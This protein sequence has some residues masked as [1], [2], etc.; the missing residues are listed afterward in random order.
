MLAS[1]LILAYD[2]IVPRFATPLLHAGIG[3]AVL[4]RATVGRNAWIGALAVIRADGHDVKVGD[5]FH[6][7]ARSTLH[8]A[9][10]LFPCIVGDR[11]SVGENS[12]VHACT[13]G[14][15]VVIGD[16]VVI[17]DGAI[18][19][20]VVVFESNSTAFPGKRIA[21]GQVYAGSPA[22]PVRPVTLEEITQLRAGIAARRANPAASNTPRHDLA[23]NSSI[24]PSVF[25]AS[26]ATVKGRLNMA[27]GT[28]CFFSNDFDA[29][30]GTI[31]IGLRTNV[32]DNTVIRCTTG[33]GVIIGR[34]S[35][36]GHNVTIPDC[37]IGNNSRLGI[38]SHV[39]PGTVIPDH[40][41]LAASARTAPGQVLESGFL[42]VGN[43]AKKFAPLDRGKREM[44]AT[45]IEHYCHYARVYKAAE[46][47]LLKAR[48]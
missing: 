37:V 48:A 23:K 46:R 38:G 2:G 44:I 9:Q 14:N 10:D 31:T 3:S 30:P 34:D 15:D 17:L 12:C 40:V 39:S 35:T 41:L 8:I 22:K 1:P 43:P 47:E 6:L 45:I 25:I 18:V 11:V 26:T 5:D 7:G 16:N 21:G 33:Q 24:D 28:S 20:D 42:Y 4:G 27:E 19:D 29:G 32:Q 13:V 36:V